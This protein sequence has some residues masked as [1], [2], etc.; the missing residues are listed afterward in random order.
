MGK[1]HTHIVT[2]THIDTHSMTGINPQTQSTTGKVKARTY[3]VQAKKHRK[4]KDA[5]SCYHSLSCFICVS[6]HLKKKTFY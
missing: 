2:D 1:N 4:E 5:K 6:A 3:N